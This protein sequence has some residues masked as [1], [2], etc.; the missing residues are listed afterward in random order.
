MLSV[1][2]NDIIIFVKYE[3]GLLEFF[4][5]FK[6]YYLDFGGLVLVFFGCNLFGKDYFV[7][8]RSEV[9]CLRFFVLLEFVGCN[10]CVLSYKE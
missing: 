2:Y 3:E 4:F 5:R 10:V 1:I 8:F 6:G 9:S 7:F